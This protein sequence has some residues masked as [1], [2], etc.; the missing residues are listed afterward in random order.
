[1]KTK[2]KIIVL[3][4]LSLLGS[5]SYAAFESSYY[6][7]LPVSISQ[8]E[9]RVLN[10]N[11]NHSRLYNLNYLNN[12]G[13]SIYWIPNYHEF[14]GKFSLTGDS[15]YQEQFFKFI[16]G[17]PVTADHSI[18]AGINFNALYIKNY[19][20]AKLYSGDIG[21][22]FNLKNDLWLLVWFGNLL[23]DNSSSIIN[24][25]PQI[26]VLD[27][28]YLIN[29]KLVVSYS[30]QSNEDKPISN[31]FSWKYYP[32]HFFGLSVGYNTGSGEINTI[33]EVG[34]KFLIGKCKINI[35]PDL[36]LWYDSTISLS[37]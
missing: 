10:I 21:F 8:P 3:Y 31:E 35:H 19:G 1:M 37:F 23:K 36:G 25:M 28:K 4:I 14:A 16:A 6:S 12:S 30:F 29:K 7:A 15:I 13:F 17:K 2:L 26:L 9:F 18:F 5:N 11:F 20:S 27:T 33:F 32:I 34:K 24:D 22:R